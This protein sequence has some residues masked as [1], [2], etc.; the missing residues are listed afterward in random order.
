MTNVNITNYL[1]QKVSINR[2][3]FL[4]LVQTFGIPHLGTRMRMRL[5]SEM[6]KE[7]KKKNIKILDAGCGFGFNSSKLAE[8]GDVTAIDNNSE[9]LEIAKNLDTKTQVKFEKADIF[10]L[11]FSNGYFDLVLC[12]EVL[13]HLK[14]DQK[15]L[16]ELARVL[17]KS[18]FLMISFYQ[19]EIEPK[20]F[21]KLHQKFKE[22]DHVR[23]GYTSTQMEKM[24]NK[25]GG[26]VILVKPYGKSWVG[27]MAIQIDARIMEVSAFLPVL[28][29]PILFPMLILDQYFIA[30]GEPYAYIFLAKVNHLKNQLP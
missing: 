11:P 7:I 23:P 18:G 25:L 6:V 4:F 26:E 29:F 12:F 9:R 20:K 14:A 28:A 16:R 22:I 10:K 2:S 3:L 21:A 5:M 30:S 8:V 27:K 1:N 24:L 19:F 17:K 15:A 13:E